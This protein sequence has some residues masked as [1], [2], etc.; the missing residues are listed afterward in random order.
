MKGTSLKWTVLILSISFFQAA[1][2][3]TTQQKD[4]TQKILLAKASSSKPAKS[5]LRAANVSYPEL[6]EDE[7]AAT[8]NYVETYAEKNRNHLINLYNK[9]KN[10]LPKVVPILKKQ[11]IPVEFALLMA[12]ESSFNANALSKM[13]ALGYWQFMPAAAK[14]YGLKVYRSPKTKK[15][16]DERKNLL[17]S[18]AAAAKYF[19]DKQAALGGDWLLTAASY[20]CGLGNV[21]KAIKKSGKSNPSFWD[22]KPYLPK[23]TQAY[24]LKFIAVNVIFNNYNS[25][26]ENDLVFKD[27]FAGSSS[28]FQD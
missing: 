12:I 6:F 21:K 25:F 10:F 16:V 20:N 23:E 4:S 22:I 11:N 1:K 24:V 13:G 18:T 19:N 5:L 14:E 17:K 27:I 2:A 15:L 9:G 3:A 8:A 26:L 7:L 28:N